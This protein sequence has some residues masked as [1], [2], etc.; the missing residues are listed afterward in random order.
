ME[1]RKEIM[2]GVTWFIDENDNY[3]SVEYFGNERR[4]I[5][6][7]ESLID[8]KNCENCVSCENCENCEDCEDC[9]SCKNCKNC[10]LCKN[11][12]GYKEVI[13]PAD[14]LS[15]FEDSY[16]TDKPNSWIPDS[17]NIIQPKISF[18]AFLTKN[19]L[20]KLDEERRDLSDKIQ[21]LNSLL[22]GD[23]KLLEEQFKARFRRSI[24][25]TF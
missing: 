1:H 5:K 13:E 15:K 16:M 22:E 11:C 12:E 17:V 14:T 8:C 6:A 19:L 9:V 10:V 7:L 2:N 21:N 20:E 25:S 4:A 3:C 23:T 24:I 18:T